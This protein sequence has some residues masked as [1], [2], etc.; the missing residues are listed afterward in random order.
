[1]LAQR[2]KTLSPPNVTV[3]RHA[4]AVR[5]LKKESKSSRVHGLSG[6]Q[7]V[8]LG[9]SSLL[10]MA[11]AG[12]LCYFLVVVGPYFFHSIQSFVFELVKSLDE[13]QNVPIRHFASLSDTTNFTVQSW[14]NK[15]TPFL[16]SLK[17]E[18]GTQLFSLLSSSLQEEDAETNNE[19]KEEEVET[20][21]DTHLC[22]ELK[23]KEDTMRFITSDWA[24]S[25]DHMNLVT[26]RSR[27]GAGA[28]FAQSKH[29]INFVTKG[30]QHWVLFAPNKIPPMY[31]INPYN[32]TLRKWLRVVYPN[33][34]TKMT[35]YEVIQKPGEALYV[36]EGYFYAYMS[37]TEHSESVLMK[38]KLEEVGT[39]FYYN[40]RGWERMNAQ[41]FKGAEKLFRLGMRETDASYV[42][43][44]SLA[45]ALQA[46]GDYVAAEQ[47]YRDALN[48]N[49]RNA[50]VI[51]S[52]IDLVR[53]NPKK[54]QKKVTEE[55]SALSDAL[56]HLQNM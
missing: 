3:A 31:G 54:S 10:S 36:P 21:S 6:K 19:E 17:E 20:Y 12:I 40:L 38:S 22:E 52:L 30:E 8:G 28:Y 37:Q 35:P 49:K 2:K 44:A 48:Q 11:M 41:D 5:K 27:E 34:K 7:L 4:A 29:L 42:I 47:A 23:K 56:K 13:E 46:Q 55:L 1:M 53:V 32:E 45:D 43:Y 18:E 50:F 39:A 24:N 14:L 25:F 26:C 9:L 33:I 51:Q 16:F 15:K